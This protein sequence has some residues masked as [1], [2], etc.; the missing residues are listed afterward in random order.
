MPLVA[1]LM[2]NLLPLH[3]LSLAVCRLFS[4]HEIIKYNGHQVSS[5]KSGAEVG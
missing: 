4:V 3:V 5:S 2:A 1:A